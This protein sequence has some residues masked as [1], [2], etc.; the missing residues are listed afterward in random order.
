MSNISAE[1]LRG[2]RLRYNVSKRKSRDD[3]YIWTVYAGELAVAQGWKR[4]LREAQETGG[5]KLIDID[6]LRHREMGN[7]K[8][9]I[10]LLRASLVVGVQPTDEASVLRYV[11][12]T[13][14]PEL[15][16]SLLLVPCTSYQCEGYAKHPEVA[17]LAPDQE[18]N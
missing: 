18:E 17:M 7:L 4:T 16:I 8:F 1:Y 13:W 12:Q 10:V 11:M 9:H 14:K 6:R 2:A 3:C 5:E 15:G